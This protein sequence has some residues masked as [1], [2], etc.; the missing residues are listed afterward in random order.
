MAIPV[1]YA[2]T[3]VVTFVVYGSDKRAAQSGRWRTQESTLQCLSLIG[4]WPGAL[5]AQRFFHHKSKKL[6]FQVVFWFTVA[7]N[8][9][10]LVW[11]F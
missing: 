10:A 4:G 11:L 2:V 1:L 5:A 7:F 3:S 9:G 8:C 6:S